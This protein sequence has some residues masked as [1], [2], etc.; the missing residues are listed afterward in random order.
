[1]V[2][3]W[4]RIGSLGPDSSKRC[5]RRHSR[6]EFGERGIDFRADSALPVRYKGKLLAWSYRTDFI[7]FES[8]LVETKGSSQL[9]G[10]DRGQV[11]NALAHH[12]LRS[13]AADQL[14]N[15]E[16]SMRTLVSGPQASICEN[17]RE[18]DG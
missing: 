11:I 3:R 17:L 4:R 16:P 10:T 1:M 9:T 14:W 15:A 12:R 18:F 13:S 8:V 7:C 2:R 6:I 5:T